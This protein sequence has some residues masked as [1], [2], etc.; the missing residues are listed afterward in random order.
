VHPAHAAGVPTNGVAAAAAGYPDAGYGD[1]FS[2]GD[3]APARG[4]R[5]VRRGRHIVLLGFGA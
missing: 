5:W 1:D 4:G 2:V 3:Y